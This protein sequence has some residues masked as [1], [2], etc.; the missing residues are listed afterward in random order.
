MRAR[1]S[2][3]GGA[4]RRAWQAAKACG[5]VFTRDLLHT[6]RRRDLDEVSSRLAA[7]TGVP[8][9]PSAEGEH[10]AGAY[11]QRVAL[12]SGRFVVID[13]S[14]G[15][16]P[17]PCRPALE[18]RLGQHISGTMKGRGVDWNFGRNRDRS[19]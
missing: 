5:G 6:L 8:Y 14:L 3:S 18:Q 12:A 11:R 10:I 2:G 1:G 13:D 15:F 4:S 17:V 7:E 19:I 16:Q 9:R